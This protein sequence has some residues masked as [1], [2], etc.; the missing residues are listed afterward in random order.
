[1]DYISTKEAA[2]K[3]GVSERL[4]Q[5]LCKENRIPGV[6]RFV[7][8]WAIPTDAKKPKDGRIKNVR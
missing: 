2:E 4:I 8:V 7:R 6:V 5:K 1:M 3:W